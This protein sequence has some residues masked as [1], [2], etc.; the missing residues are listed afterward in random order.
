[1]VVQ[2]DPFEEKVDAMLSY[3]DKAREM[4]ADDVAT[5]GPQQNLESDVKAVYFNSVDKSIQRANALIK[6]GEDEMA[7]R[8]VIET[9]G[10]RL[11][12]E[13]KQWLLKAHQSI[14]SYNRSVVLASYFFSDQVAKLGL[15]HGSDYWNYSFPKAYEKSV[16]KY[17]KQWGTP[18][19]LIWSIM[20][21]ET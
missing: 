14:N 9:E 4:L 17:S 8:E 5:S 10:Q 13:Q 15:F 16:K 21:A 1:L 2:K 3:E 20:R 18:Q 19:E 12:N 6:V 7:Y 11:T